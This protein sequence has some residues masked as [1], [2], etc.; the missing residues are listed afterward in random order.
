MG[1][2]GLIK[3][4]ICD[5]ALYFN[6][7]SIVLGIPNT[8]GDKEIEETFLF[9][10]K[11][12]AI[13]RYVPALKN[14]T[15]KQILAGLVIKPLPKPSTFPKYKEENSLIIVFSGKNITAKILAIRWNGYGWDYQLENIG[16]KGDFQAEDKVRKKY[17]RR[18]K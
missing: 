10:T 11:H 12:K 13:I 15:D 4:I 16:H 2:E 7:T 5:R 9:V 1:G 17:E 6:E 14:L 18:S 8:Y 3:Y